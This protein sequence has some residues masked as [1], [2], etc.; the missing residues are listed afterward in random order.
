M[1]H[2]DSAF[3]QQGTCQ[4]IIA[5]GCLG[6]MRPI[7]EDHVE[8]LGPRCVDDRALSNQ[9][10]DLGMV[11]LWPVGFI[12]IIEASGIDLVEKSLYH[13]KPLAQKGMVQSSHHLGRLVDAA[14]AHVGV[15]RH[16]LPLPGCACLQEKP[17][18]Y[19]NET[20]HL[21]DALRAQ[22]FKQTDQLPCIMELNAACLHVLQPCLQGRFAWSR[23]FDL[24]EF[25]LDRVVELQKAKW[26]HGMG[27]PFM[28]PRRMPNYGTGLS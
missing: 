6:I 22:G 10:I 9:R 24:P 11:Q 14:V 4:A 16:N 17:A 20:S 12:F 2:H 28:Q 3:F 7:D 23:S 8:T 19:P 25:G 18:G 5:Q 26:A 27:V 15:Q 13:G 21:E 1:K